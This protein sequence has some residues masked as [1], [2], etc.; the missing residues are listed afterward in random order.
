MPWWFIFWRG[1]Q[2]QTQ[3]FHILEVLKLVYFYIVWL[4]TESPI[5]ILLARHCAFWYLLKLYSAAFFL[6]S[7]VLSPSKSTQYSRKSIGYK[8]YSNFYLVSTEG[9]V[10]E[11]RSIFFFFSS[12]LRQYGGLCAPYTVSITPVSLL[13]VLLYATSEV[14]KL[15]R[16]RSWVRIHERKLRLMNKIAGIE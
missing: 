13:P 5:S 7:F 8:K 4:T 16:N 1:K 15:G 14:L 2:T 11:K 10:G 9:V 12:Y 3:S 6:Y